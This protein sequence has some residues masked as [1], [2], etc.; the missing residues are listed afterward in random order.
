MLEQ[1]S[2]LVEKKSYGQINLNSSLKSWKILTKQQRCCL[3]IK[4]RVESVVER[5]FPPSPSSSSSQ[6]FSSLTTTTTATEYADLFTLHY[7]ENCLFSVRQLDTG[8]V[9]V[10]GLLASD[11]LCFAILREQA[12]MHELKCQ[13]VYMKKVIEISSCS[14][15]S[16]SIYICISYIY[17]YTILF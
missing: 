12:E 11:T 4:S 5:F 14:S 3:L 17:I 8:Q 10:F 15:S 13:E 1:V 2:G 7:S 16:S 9:S 6:P